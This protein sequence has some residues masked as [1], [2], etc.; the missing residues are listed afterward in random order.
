MAPGGSS[1]RLGD[2]L[3][4]LSRLRSEDD[5][6]AVLTLADVLA[7]PL[8]EAATRAIAG[9]HPRGERRDADRSR[10]SRQ[11]VGQQRSDATAVPAVVDHDRDVGARGIGCVADE[12]RNPD[13]VASGC[14]DRDE[15]LVGFMVDPGQVV[16]LTLGEVGDREEEALVA[17]AG[18]EA[19][20]ARTEL[21]PVRGFDRPDEDAGAVGQDSAAY[22]CSS[23]LL[24]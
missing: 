5:R 9:E 6:G 11:P 2:R 10:P 18:V 15:R 4:V 14:V 12:A 17:G 23:W 21:R 19:V 22:S 3:C 24:M 16:E 7:D 8:D 13:A 1:R 20:E